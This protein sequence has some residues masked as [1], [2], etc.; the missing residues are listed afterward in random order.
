MKLIIDIAEKDYE[1]LKN[2]GITLDWN[3]IWHGKEKDKELTFAIFNLVKAL[4]NGTSIALRK[5]GAE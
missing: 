5:G 2:T 3:T 1:L 4:G